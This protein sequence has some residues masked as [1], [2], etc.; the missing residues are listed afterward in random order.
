MNPIILSPNAMYQL[1][2][3]GELYEFF[4]EENIEVNNGD[5]E[6]AELLADGIFAG[7]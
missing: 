2:A 3:N 6:V 5:L 4:N 7:R 1:P